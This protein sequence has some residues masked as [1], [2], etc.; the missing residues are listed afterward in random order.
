[1]DS[2]IIRQGEIMMKNYMNFKNSLNKV[3]QN[4][5]GIMDIIK[6]IL[7]IWNLVLIKKKII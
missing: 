3:D 6:K 1:M 7:L 2:S 4:H 5:L